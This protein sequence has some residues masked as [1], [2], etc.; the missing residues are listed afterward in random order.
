MF[1]QIAQIFTQYGMWG[2]FALAFLDS[3][4]LPVPPFFLQIGMSLV[5]PG[6]ALRYA[7][8]AFTGSLLGAPVGY[9]LGKWLGKP[10]MHKIVPAKWTQAA[11]EVFEKNGDGAVLI[12]S[13]TPIPFK[14]FTVLSGVFGYSLTKLMFFAI[15]GRGLK[16]YLIGILF[17]LYGKHAKVL[18]DEYLEITLLGVAAV[19]AIGWYIWKKRKESVGRK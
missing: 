16:F 13:F 3:F 7:T 9:L 10:L 6:A 8:V 12:G 19:V 18:L 11:T 5:E 2:L 14:V 17:Y 4:I 1:D 15:L